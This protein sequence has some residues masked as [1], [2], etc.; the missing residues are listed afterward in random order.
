MSNKS[1]Y[2]E[3]WEKM[4]NSLKEIGFSKS[5]NLLKSFPSFND[6]LFFPDHLFSNFEKQ[7]FEERKEKF[8]QICHTYPL[9]EED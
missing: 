6:I 2:A 9:S 7:I 8:F 3:S 1:Y 5:L 4:H